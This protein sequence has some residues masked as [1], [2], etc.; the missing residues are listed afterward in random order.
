[1]RKKRKL[2]A[3]LMML[4]M[5]VTLVAGCSSGGTEKKKTDGGG[6]KQGQ[7]TEA[8]AGSGRFFENEITLPDGIDR[9]KSLKKLS[10]GSLGA[11][12]EDSG[13]RVYF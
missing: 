11:V 2:T 10:D 5:V 13:E 8:K 1:M 7:G 9:I 6:L 3:L 12:G 4:A